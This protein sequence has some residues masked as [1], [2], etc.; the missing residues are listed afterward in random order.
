[1]LIFAYKICNYLNL[2]NYVSLD[3]NGDVIDVDQEFIDFVYTVMVFGAATYKLFFLQ[4]LAEVMM[5]E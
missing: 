4:D 1:M 5:I 3:V 2:K